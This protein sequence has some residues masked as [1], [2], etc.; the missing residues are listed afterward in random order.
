MIIVDTSVWIEYFK[1]HRPF[2]EIIDHL[3]SHQHIAA[4][5]VIF[6]ELL[7][8]AKNRREREHIKHY[9]HNL[10]RFNDEHMLIH[11]GEFAGLNKFHSKGVGLVDATIIWAAREHNALVWSLDTRLQAQL[12]ES[13]KFPGND[14]KLCEFVENAIDVYHAEL[15]MEEEGATSHD[16]LMKEL[17][18]LR[19]MS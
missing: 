9:W 2:L 17:G 10:P 14:T 3:F 13:E 4:L 11:A 6:A 19:K 5:E 1:G 12:E 7:Q 8:G 15:A 18:M 16:E